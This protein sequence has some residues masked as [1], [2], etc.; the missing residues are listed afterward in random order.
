MSG[1]PK[2]EYILNQKLEIKV[3]GNVYLFIFCGQKY[4]LYYLLI[5]GKILSSYILS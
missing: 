3:Y 4:S 2:I 1:Q 5:Y